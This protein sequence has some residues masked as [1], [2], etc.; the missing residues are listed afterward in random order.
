LRGQIGAGRALNGFEALGGNWLTWKSGVLGSGL[1]NACSS[2]FLNMDI[3]FDIK[4]TGR[5]TQGSV[6]IMTLKE[7]CSGLFFA[8][9]GLSAT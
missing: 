5:K 4:C 2:T 9:S 1:P 6:K 7:R 3:P 8:L